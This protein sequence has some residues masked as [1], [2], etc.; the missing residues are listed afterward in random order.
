MLKILNPVIWLWNFFKYISHLEM[1]SV[2]P[3]HVEY[4]P[5]DFEKYDTTYFS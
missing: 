5:Y 3:R 4:E 1:Y 2:P